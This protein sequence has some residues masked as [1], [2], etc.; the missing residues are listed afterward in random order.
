[1]G[2]CC[3]G[4]GTIS[5]LH[6]YWSIFLDVVIEDM[7]EIDSA[8]LICVVC[9]MRSLFTHLCEDFFGLRT[10]V[11]WPREPCITWGYRSPHG[12]GRFEGEGG[13]LLWS[14]GTLCGRLCKKRLKWLICRLGCGLRWAEGGTS[15]IVFV[16]WRQCAL[17]GGSLAP[18]GKYD[19]T[20]HLPRGCGLMSNYFGHLFVCCRS[21][22]VC[23]ATK[24]SDFYHIF[25]CLWHHTNLSRKCSSCLFAKILEL[26][27]D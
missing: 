10:Q 23:V 6:K 27:N 1:M 9:W 24:E 5:D 14:I 19:W 16:R 17:M 11:G 7:F 26:S 25:S 12:K 21:L 2:V 20:V 13:I 8:V 3:S 15:S 18:P 22:F 4:K